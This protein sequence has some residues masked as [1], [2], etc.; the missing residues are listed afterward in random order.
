MM[1]QYIADFTKHLNQALEIGKNTNFHPVDKEIKS[2]LICGLGGSGIGGSIISQLLAPELS[3]PVVINKDY[4]IPAFVNEST[5]V[6]CCSYSGNTEETL[7][8]YDQAIAKSA[9]ICIITSGGKFEDLAKSKQH[10]FIKIPEGY[11]PRAAFGLSFPQL[12]YAFN[13]YSLIDGSFEKSLMNS[14]SLIDQEEESIRTE[15]KELASRLE[16]KI[17][18]LYCESTNE[19]VAIRLRQQINEN[20]KM[21]CWHH[22]IPEMNHNELVGWRFPKEEVAVVFLESQETY[23]RNAKRMEYCKNVIK[24]YASSI[25]SIKAKGQNSIEESLYL[26]H[27][28][29]WISS[30]LADLN[31]IDAIEIEVIIGLK[32]TL[33]KLK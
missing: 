11:P 18:V 33:S 29:D 8:M 25:D 6:M 20:S 10:N 16:G 23:Y 12:F 5:L 19:G 31:N 30:Y 3:I 9:E 22:V 21:L 24:K 26:I 1:N 17:P 28:G 15:A 4:H 27:L 13:K 2:V 14:I 7:Q 32:D